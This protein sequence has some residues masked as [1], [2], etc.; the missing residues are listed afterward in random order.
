M[1]RAVRI[2]VLVVLAVFVFEGAAGSEALA[3]RKRRRRAPR[4]RDQI[5]VR[6]VEIAGGVAYLTPG[7]RAG[8]RAGQTARIGRQRYRIVAVTRDS[9][10]IELG[11]AGRGLREGLRGQVKKSKRQPGQEG[12]E[13][14][15]PVPPDAFAR[16]WRPARLPAQAQAPDPVP[17]MGVP[18]DSGRVRAAVYG[19]AAS[20]I[21]LQG[22]YDPVTR[23]AV[24]GRLHAEPWRS[25]PV[26]IDADLALTHWSGIELDPDF[27]AD[28]RP[29]LRVRELRLRYG[30]ERSPLA[31][32]GRL[33]Y[34]AA[35][36]GAL[37]GVRVR[38][39][40]LGGLS[41]AAFGGYVPDPTT[42]E[43]D[44]GMSRFGVEL[45]YSDPTST[46]RPSAELVAHGSR[47]DGALDERRLSA[48]AGVH[49]EA[50]SLMGYAE[51]SAFERDNPWGAEPVELTAAGVDTSVRAG[52]VQL[53]A[54]LDRRVPE[55]SR[56][57]ASLLPQ[58]W[59]CTARPSAEIDPVSEPC[60]GQRH[61]RT[62]ATADARYQGRAVAVTAGASAVGSSSGALSEELAAFADLR[63][64]GVVRRGRLHLGALITR[65][66][67][68]STL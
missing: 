43:P 57:L 47:F 32:I 14:R 4:T 26:G 53:G 52:A 13:R 1:S 9:A 30:D 51:L 34:A 62:L 58:S 64:T 8:L 27:G 37:D 2:A 29:P 21:P 48:Y 38:T 44:L 68:L 67:L 59:L 46:W 41:L 10:V 5:T 28:S 63:A 3:Q 45:A 15:A 56:W 23:L 17:L 25:T 50:L 54:R 36:V 7:E 31:G 20:V 55:R 60:D 24:G 65:G 18:G 61:A 19:T 39:P 42:T 35:T 16:V 40:R 12:R 11:K 49:G 33:R 22:E 66:G 6:V